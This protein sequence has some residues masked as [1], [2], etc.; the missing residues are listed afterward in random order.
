MRLPGAA[1][2]VIATPG[3]R[4]AR[5]S[6]YFEVLAERA[7]FHRYGDNEVALRWRGR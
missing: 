3:W 1:V 5:D 7:A 6:H 2:R 4:P